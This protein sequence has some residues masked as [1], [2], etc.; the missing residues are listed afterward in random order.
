MS[1]ISVD[2]KRE[3]VGRNERIV[4][5]KKSLDNCKSPHLTRILICHRLNDRILWKK[6]TIIFN[7]S[8]D[9]LGLSK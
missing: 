1:R 8:M 7:I 3:R 9:F 6:N 2:E 5:K 4:S